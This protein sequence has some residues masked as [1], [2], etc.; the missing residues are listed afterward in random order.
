MIVAG[1]DPSLRNWGVSLFDYSPSSLVLLKVGIVQTSKDPSISRNKD[2]LRRAQELRLSLSKVKADV[3]VA[4]LPTGSQ[5][6][7]SMKSY[8]IVMGILSMF[9]PL[10]TVTP[11]D[12]KA[13]IGE[14]ETTK[15]EIICWTR[16]LYPSMIPTQLN[17]AEHVSDS[18]LA[19]HASLKKLRS[20][21]ENPNHR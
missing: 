10:I 1:F 3:F 16:D 2:D 18:I 5:S 21:Y 19:V 17:K 4:E 12:V 8:G 6:A 11:Y 9:D 15:K 7:V 20:F 13:V 14:R